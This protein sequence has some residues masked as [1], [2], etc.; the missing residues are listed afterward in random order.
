[1]SVRNL[2][3]A[4]GILSLLA[5]VA[6]S[7]FWLRQPARSARNT[8]QPVAQAV[9]VAARALPVGTVLGAADMTWK[10]ISDREVRTGNLVR[11]QVAE[12]E[13]IGAV[14]RRAFVA[15]EPL[16]ASDLVKPNSRQFLAAV[17]KPGMRAISIPVDASQSVSGL[18]QPG[19]R[20]DIIFTQSLAAGDE[21]NRQSPL[22]F[23]PVLPDVRVIAVD[24]SLAATTSLP[25][26]L[27]GAIASQVR[28]LPKTVTLEV[29][30]QQAEEVA[31]ALQLG[32][33]QLT[34][35]A[36]G[37]GG[38]F[39]EKPNQSARGTQVSPALEE[40]TEP[41]PQSAIEKNVRLPPVPAK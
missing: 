29:T 33:L 17:L 23:P 7:V 30:Q 5:S 22:Q 6:L 20:V 13:F 40:L 16:T 41:R 18:V 25:A 14:T 31:V 4:V 15:G 32:R 3:L 19:D 39:A 37:A 38:A 27:G 11:G 10:E 24:Q 12:N 21:K 26:Q 34:V 9:L 28:L 8:P 36:L 1:M 2:L 35:R